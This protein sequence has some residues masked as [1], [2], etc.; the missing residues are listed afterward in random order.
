MDELEGIPK[1]KT[2][3][4]VV[5][6]IV[7]VAILGVGLLDRRATTDRLIGGSSLKGAMV[8]SVMYRAR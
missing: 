3:L 1:S 5:V 7:G 6:V 4:I 8:F 2:G